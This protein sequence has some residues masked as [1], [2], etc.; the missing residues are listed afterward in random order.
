VENALNKTVG[1]GMRCIDPLIIGAGASIADPM[2][3][4]PT[5][6]KISLGRGGSWLNRCMILISWPVARISGLASS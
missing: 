2:L 5:V 4:S 1:M 3:S 6:G